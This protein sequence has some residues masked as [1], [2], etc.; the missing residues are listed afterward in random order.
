MTDEHGSRVLAASVVVEGINLT[1][2]PTM[3]ASKN[4]IRLPV[5]GLGSGPTESVLGAMT[6]LG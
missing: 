6:V 4:F 5:E 1:S 2:R 3:S